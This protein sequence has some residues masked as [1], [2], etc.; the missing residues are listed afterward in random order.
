MYKWEAVV[1][2][3]KTNEVHFLVVKITSIITYLTII[4]A[5]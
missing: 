2:L 1:L 4:Y 3:L 5:K